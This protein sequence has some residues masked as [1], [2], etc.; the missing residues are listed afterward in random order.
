MNSFTRVDR[1]FAEVINPLHNLENNPGPPELKEAV[2]LIGLGLMCRALAGR[3]RRAD[4]KVIGWDIDP[5]QC[6]ALAKS[7]ARAA[8]N[9]AELLGAH[10]RVLLSL[11]D[12]DTVCQLLR[13]REAELRPGRSFSTLPRAIRNRP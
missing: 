10:R 8:G 4:F 6:A 11:P 9:L 3:V 12:Q 7:G 1:T 2:G 13:S 5:D